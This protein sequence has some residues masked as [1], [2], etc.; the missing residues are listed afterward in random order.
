M[1]IRRCGAGCNNQNA[2]HSNAMITAIAMTILA[3]DLVAVRVGMFLANHI[4][5]LL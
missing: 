3:D 4:E 5:C 1:T 2:V